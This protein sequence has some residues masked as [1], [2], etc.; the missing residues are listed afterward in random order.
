[1]KC[2]DNPRSLHVLYAS[3]GGARVEALRQVL[4]NRGH[5]ISSVSNLREILV[6]EESHVLVLDAVGKDEQHALLL[7][8]EIQHA[9][10]ELPVVMVYD[11]RS[12]ELCRSAA[13]FGVA[14]LI[15]GAFDPTA[16][17]NSVEHCA[18]DH[19]PDAPAR[20]GQSAR[21]Q[22]QH[23]DAEEALAEL[24]RYLEE[25]H[26][27]AAHIARALVASAELIDNAQRH[28]GDAGTAFGVAAE[29]HNSRLW[30]AISDHGCGLK[31]SD[32]R[33]EAA[34]AALPKPR[35]VKAISAGA[36][37][38]HGGI[39]RAARLAER[40]EVSSQEQGT[41]VELEFELFPVSCSARELPQLDSLQP[42]PMRL[43]IHSME[44]GRL[45][46]EDISPVLAL[47]AQRLVGAATSQLRSLRKV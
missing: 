40:F 46:I 4:L 44:A 26:L 45:S 23:Q 37:R 6:A 43:L 27:A 33:L 34:A 15:Q 7:L 24:S 13:E 31:E 39:S 25:A 29:V 42:K 28:S 2:A 3:D 1:M 12:F 20:I 21:Y 16:L 5:R 38:V 30:L 8:E 35:R 14:S 9:G 41:T 22:A 36:A 11:Q 32:A 17:T 19:S 10:C 47:T 18:D